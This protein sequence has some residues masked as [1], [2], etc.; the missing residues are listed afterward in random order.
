MFA[1]RILYLVI[2]STIANFPSAHA[3]VGDLPTGI[4][5][6][7]T[8]QELEAAGEAN[9]WALA[10]GSWFPETKTVEGTDLTLYFCDQVLWTIDEHFPG[11]FKEFVET[12][13]RLEIEHGE[14]ETDVAFLPAPTSLYLADANFKTTDGLEINVQVY[15]KDDQMTLWSRTSTVAMCD[16]D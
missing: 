2:V 12:V 6:G 4:V 3:Q 5:I 9:G 11:G 14:A 16:V 1:I 10:P 15:T 7:K 8:L 13:L